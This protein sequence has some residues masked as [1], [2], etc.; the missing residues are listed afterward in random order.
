VVQE[1]GGRGL[2]QRLK[3]W[4]IGPDYNYIELKKVSIKAVLYTTVKAI[5]KRH[6]I[7]LATGKPGP[8]EIDNNFVLAL[9]G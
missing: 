2:G 4:I 6:Q 1:G 7:S 3:Y 8:L 9:T 5:T